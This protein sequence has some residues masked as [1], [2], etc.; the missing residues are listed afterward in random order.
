MMD[1]LWVMNIGEEMSALVISCVWWL[2]WVGFLWFCMVATLCV[3]SNSELI[4]GFVLLLLGWYWL[5][6]LF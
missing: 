1:G 4:I 5:C 3:R 6:C 2:L